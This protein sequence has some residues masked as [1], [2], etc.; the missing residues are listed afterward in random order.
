[1]GEHRLSGIQKK[2][3]ELHDATELTSAVSNSQRLHRSLPDGKPNQ[4][5]V[6]CLETADLYVAFSHFFCRCRLWQ[7]G[8]VGFF[9]LGY[10]PH[11]QLTAVHTRSSVITELVFDRPIEGGIS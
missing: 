10:V 11:S 5:V 7:E 9:I 3:K 8:K 4:V 1:M 6:R 2:E